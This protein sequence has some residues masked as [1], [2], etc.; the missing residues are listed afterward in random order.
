MKVQIEDDYRYVLMISALM[1]FECLVV[2]FVAGS[3]RSKI[4][5]EEFMS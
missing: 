4:F 1:A 3:K 2:G 5:S